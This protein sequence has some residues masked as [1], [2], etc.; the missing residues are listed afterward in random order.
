MADGGQAMKCSFKYLHYA[1]CICVAQGVAK[2]G[3]SALC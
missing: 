2:Y 1:V 3:G